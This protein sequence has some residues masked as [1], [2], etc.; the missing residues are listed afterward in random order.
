MW[1]QARVNIPA[2]Y[3]FKVKINRL[4]IIASVSILGYVDC[5]KRK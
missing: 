4:N 3:D 2:G 5:N 1:A